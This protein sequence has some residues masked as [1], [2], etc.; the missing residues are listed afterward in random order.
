[1]GIM[2]E[3]LFIVRPAEPRD[4]AA[5]AGLV[6]EGFLDK[7]RPIFGGGIERSVKIMERWVRLEHSLGGVSS[8]VVEGPSP[9]QVAASVGVRVGN[10]DDVALTRGL[11]KVLRRDLGY[12]R[13]LW[14]ATLLSYPRYAAISREAYVERLVVTHEHRRR[15]M[16]RALLEAA[17]ALAHD[18][19]KETVGLHVSGGNLPALKLY[20][21][22]RYEESDRQRSLLTGS[23]LGIW[24]WLYL[25]KEL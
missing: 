10:S 23:F 16:A 7:F 5:I 3:K 19:G 14:A 24:E 18:S 9:A 8:L 1:M 20:E 4:N 22:Y 17:E 11:W 6:V 12:A 2:Q 21:A 13:A 15:G 25:K